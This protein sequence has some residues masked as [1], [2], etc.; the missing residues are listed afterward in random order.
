[1]AFHEKFEIDKET[2]FLTPKA[3]AAIK[4]GFTASQKTE[5]LKLFRSSAN[6]GKASKAI[7][8]DRATVADHRRGDKKFAIEYQKAIEDICDDMEQC[9]FELA[10]R[11]PTAAFGILKAYRGK[12]WKE[13]YREKEPT[14]DEKLKGLLKTLKE[15]DNG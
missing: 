3:D 5:Y 8:V 12:I 10:K 13:S 6:A 1:M 2:G 4:N 15:E 9:L 7:G 14:K 11:N